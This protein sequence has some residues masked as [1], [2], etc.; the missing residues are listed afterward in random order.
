[1][2]CS[3]GPLADIHTERGVRNWRNSIT[4]GEVSVHTMATFNSQS[5]ERLATERLATEA[6]RASEETVPGRNE[7]A[8]RQADS[9]QPNL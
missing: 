6:L 4:G 1:M 5:S 7:K 2:W 9:M 8:R 3:L